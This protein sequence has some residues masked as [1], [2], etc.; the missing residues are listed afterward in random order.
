MGG[1]Q[2]GLTIAQNWGPVWVGFNWSD[3]VYSHTEVYDF[4]L[5]VYSDKFYVVSHFSFCDKFDA[6]IFFTY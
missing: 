3:E 4:T 1:S 2:W 5:F 6:Y